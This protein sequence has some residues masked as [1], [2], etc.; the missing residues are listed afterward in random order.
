M[1]PSTSPGI[2]MRPARSICRV[3]GLTQD[4]ES[5]IAPDVHDAARAH[6]ERLLHAVAR[7]NRVHDAVA[8]HR[9][10]GTSC[11]AGFGA[12]RPERDQLRRGKRRRKR[13][14]AAAVKSH[15]SPDRG[16]R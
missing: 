10:G 3:F 1:W 12:G 15:A 4:A 13:R 9:I 7:V 16:R 14:G 6:R 2:S 8:V 11:D 5:G